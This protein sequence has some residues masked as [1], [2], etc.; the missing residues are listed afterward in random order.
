[1]AVVDSQ[2]VKVVYNTFRSIKYT[3][4]LKANVAISTVAKTLCLTAAKLNPC[5]L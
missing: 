3:S 5:N 2:G 4:H 1:M